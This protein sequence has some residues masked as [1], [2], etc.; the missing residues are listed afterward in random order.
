MANTKRRT[1]I[2]LDTKLFKR[3]TAYGKEHGRSLSSLIEQGLRCVLDGAP[4]PAEHGNLSPVP[5]P[6]LEALADSRIQEQ[7]PQIITAWLDSARGAERLERLI[8]PYVNERVALLKG[9][10]ALSGTATPKPTAGAPTSTPKA[11]TSA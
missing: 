6:D 1:N 10:A 3:A 9:R 4:V 2:S 8:V 7:L 5:L 11:S